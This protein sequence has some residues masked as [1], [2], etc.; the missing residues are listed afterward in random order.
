[1]GWEVEA[2][3]LWFAALSQSV[4]A[5]EAAYRVAARRGMPE[6]VDDLRSKWVESM[7]ITLVNCRE[8]GRALDIASED[9]A[10]AYAYRALDNSAKD[11]LRSPSRRERAFD[12]RSELG[13]E[14]VDL[15]ETPAEEVEFNH[16]VQGARRELKRLAR[17]GY[18]GSHSCKG[19]QCVSIATACLDI[20]AGRNLVE[21]TALMRGGTTEWDRLVYA[22]IDM[23][24]PEHKGDEAGRRSA[25]TRQMK[26]RC[27]KCA[28]ALLS[29]VL[30]TMSDGSVG[31]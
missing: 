29:E 4:S 31:D 1:M 23:L 25:V 20:A 14:V 12:V 28:Q 9:D 24:Y 13:D 8:E 19:G 15:R 6:L 17:G 3:I 26:S 22:A 18:S 30:S 27:G 10:R 7:M 5:R 21:A 2:F 11:L 16:L